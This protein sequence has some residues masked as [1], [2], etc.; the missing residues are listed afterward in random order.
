[1]RFAGRHLLKLSDGTIVKPALA[2]NTVVT[3]QKLARLR[4]AQRTTDGAQ[5]PTP[6]QSSST[7]RRARRCSMTSS[8]PLYQPSGK[9]KTPHPAKDLDFSPHR[10]YSVYNWE[11]FFHVPLT[12]ALH[13]S[14]NGRFAEAQRWL[15]LL[16]DPT[17]SSDG[18][19]PERFWKVLP[20]LSLETHSVEQ[21]LVNLAKGA[22]GDVTIADA[23]RRSIEDWM[24]APF[25]PHAVARQR[26][27]AYMVKTVMAYLDNLI[28]WGDSLFRQDKG[29]AIDEAMMLYVLAANILGPRPQA[30]PR[31]GTVKPQTYNNLRGDLQLFGSVLRDLEPELPFD[32]LPTMA[33]R[34]PTAARHWPRCAA[35]AR[36]C[37]SACRATTSCW[38]TGTRSQTGC[39]RSATA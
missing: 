18:P 6:M 21:L 16:F 4:D 36:R 26:Q 31:K 15:H 22:N 35:W 39:S 25:R 3:L 28:A 11:L 2:P 14:K 37:T 9:V 29:E 5:R 13:L 30:V 38:A 7:A 24:N 27:Q 19:A 32:L 34:R 23:T 17:D 20:F 12:L 10:A 8:R 33:R 1:L